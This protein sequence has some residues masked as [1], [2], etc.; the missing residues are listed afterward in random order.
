MSVNMRREQRSRC[1]KTYSISWLDEDGLTHSAQVQG[2]DRSESGVGVLCSVEVRPGTTVYIQVQGGHPIGYSV[3]RNCRRQHADY[4]IGLELD[5]AA[6]KTGG[7]IPAH[8]AADH[9]EF[10][11]INPKAQAETIQR[12]YRFLAARFHPDNPETGDTEKFLL[13]NRAFEVLSD[14]A[15]RAEYD[16]TLRREQGRPVQAFE[17][18]DFMDGVEGEV[19]RRLAV[20]SLLYR[21][22]R[23]N[24]HDPKVSLRELE[25]LMGFPREYLDFTTWYLRNKKFITREDNSDFALTSLGVDYVESNYSKIP[26]LNR[27]LNAGMGSVNGS[28]GENVSEAPGAAHEM[29]ILGPAEV[30]TDD[31]EDNE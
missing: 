12:V 9:Y 15:R 11:Q 5:E 31:L 16:A 18:V 1:R 26:L 6:K 13:L 8:N 17:S 7:A 2:I 22:C 28:G 19:N 10:L 3:V 20:L 23:A 14:P 4:I 21:R 24:V 30:I 29:L 25:T 27:L